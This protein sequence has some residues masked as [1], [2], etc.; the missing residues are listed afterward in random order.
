MAFNHELFGIN[1]KSTK[2]LRSS[3]MASLDFDTEEEMNKQK[4]IIREGLDL[5][6]KI[7]GFRSVSFTAPCYT[8]SRSIEP[9]LYDSGVRYLKGNFIQA[10]PAHSSDKNE[11]KKRYHY[12][13][14]KN[15]N[16]Q[17]YLIRNC[18]FEPS[19]NE[20]FDWINYCLNGIDN[21]FRWRK[22]VSISMH[23]LNFI[24]FI[25]PSNRNRN[26]PEFK[27]LLKQILKKWPDTEFMTSSQLGELINSTNS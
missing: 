26:L 1:S 14:Q 23:R 8:W 11:Y 21:A 3:Y 4:N 18:F 22:P 25:D 12:M 10:E 13:G 5:F 16:H 6:E 24:G 15:K 7:Y 20:N 2:E 19:Q 9:L 17:Y 27:S